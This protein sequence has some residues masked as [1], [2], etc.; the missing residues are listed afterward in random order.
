[1]KLFVGCCC[2]KTTYILFLLNLWVH[3]FCCCAE[4]QH[5]QA[6]INNYNNNMKYTNIIHGKNMQTYSTG[7]VVD[8]G[9][10]GLAANKK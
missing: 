9:G 2:S 3:I 4:A 10:I 7:G 1:M 8:D 5:T 6:K